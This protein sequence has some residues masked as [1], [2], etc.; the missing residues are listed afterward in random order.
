MVQDF[1]TEMNIPEGK[2]S[3]STAHRDGKRFPEE[4]E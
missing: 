1:R 2:K 3:M 4:N